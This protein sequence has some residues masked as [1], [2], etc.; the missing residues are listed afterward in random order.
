M[1]YK[2]F[3]PNSRDVLFRRD[4]QFDEHYPPYSASSS[5]PNTFFTPLQNYASFEEDLDINPPSPP[6]PVVPRVPKWARDTVDA[7]GPLAG[8]PIDACRTHS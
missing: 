7:A 6:P 3:D 5:L 2:L 4:V 1:A 8:D